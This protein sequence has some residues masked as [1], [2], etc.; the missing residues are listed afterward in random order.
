[1]TDS[2][3][4][5]LNALVGAVNEMIDDGRDPFEIGA[6]FVVIGSSVVKRNFSPLDA[7][8]LLTNARRGMLAN[9]TADEI[10][11]VEA[12]LSADSAVVGNC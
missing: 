9:L 3:H 1:M 11:G 6:A 2:Y 8:E 7:L 10:A 5:L 12:G 4:R